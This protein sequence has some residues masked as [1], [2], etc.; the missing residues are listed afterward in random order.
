M[1]V[2]NGINTLL[3][4]GGTLKKNEDHFSNLSLLSTSN[5]D[6]WNTFKRKEIQFT[7]VQMEDLI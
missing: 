3:N 1:G 2:G 7:K 4:L 6:Y 5:K